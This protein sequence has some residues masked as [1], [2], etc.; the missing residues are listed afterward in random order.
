M[1]D[2]EQLSDNMLYEIPLYSISGIHKRRKLNNLQLTILNQFFPPDYAAT[3]QLIGELAYQL[4]GKFRSVE[5]FSSQPAY[6]FERD[7]LPRWDHQPGLSIRRSKSA[8]AS[9]GRIRGKT[10][11]GVVFFL[12]AIIHLLRRSDRRQLVLITT[13]PPFLPFLGY[14]VSHVCKISYICLLYDLYPDIA[15]ELNVIKKQNLLSKAWNNLNCLTWKKAAAIIVLSSTMKDKIIQKCP[16]VAHKISV[17]PNWSNPQEIQPISKSNNWFAKEHGLVDQFTVMYSGNMGRCHDLDTL[18]Y[19]IVILQNTPI[20][21]VFIGGGDKYKTMQVAIKKLNLQDNCLFLPY[22]PKENLAFSLTACD[23]SIVSIDEQMEGLIAPSKLY[24]CLAAATPIAA[25]CPS[26]S[27]LNNVF[28]EA[29]C[30]ETFRNGD[31]KGLAE[32]IYGLSLNPH[33]CQKLGQSGRD[34]CIQKN[35]LNKVADD[36]LDLFELTIN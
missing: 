25:I 1:S 34:Y 32:Y 8:N 6:A 15:I 22:Q 9:Y 24:S 5:V 36:Y 28:I 31:G 30:G 33:L 23:L 18:L 19:A 2:S 10:V 3:G 16:Q 12:R 29:K 20:K 26:H 27:Y 4:K 13:A 14:L 11:S 35:T 7:D 17:I 21:F